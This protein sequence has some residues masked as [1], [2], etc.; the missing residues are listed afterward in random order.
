MPATKDISK[1]NKQTKKKP[2]IQNPTLHPEGWV[3]ETSHL[4][5]LVWVLVSILLRG[6]TETVGEWM[7]VKGTLFW[8]VKVSRWEGRRDSSMHPRD[9]QL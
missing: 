1:E 4:L 9:R 8:A 7:D 2:K 5:L 6:E 3:N